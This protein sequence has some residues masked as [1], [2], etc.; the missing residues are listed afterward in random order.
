MGPLENED[1]VGW[2]GSKF[3]DEQ[4]VHQHIRWPPLAAHPTYARL[5]LFVFIAFLHRSH[6]AEKECSLS[7]LKWT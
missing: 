1:G 4:V 6:W 5:S 3:L 7:L 2:A